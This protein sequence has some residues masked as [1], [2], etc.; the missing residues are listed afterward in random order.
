MKN[1][2][3]T[4][5]LLFI[6]V[7]SFAQ[8]G[9]VFQGIA[10]DDQNSAMINKTLTFTFKIKD[11]S[12]TELFTENK[13]LTTDAFGVFS[14]TIGSVNISGFNSVEFTKK[15]LRLEVTVNGVSGAIYDQ[16]FQ[17]VPYAK[18]AEIATRA[19]HGVPVGTILPFMG[20]TAPEGWVMCD[21]TNISDS[22]YDALRAVL[23]TSHTPDLR[24]R[25]LKGAGTSGMGIMPTSQYDQSSLGQYQSQSIMQH[26]HDKGSIKV[27][28]GEGGHKHA[29]KVYNENKSDKGYTQDGKVNSLT[30]TNR[31][32]SWITNHSDNYQ[33]E[34]LIGHVNGT[35]HHNHT[36]EGS[37][38]NTGTKENRPWSFSVNYIIKY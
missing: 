38:A 8:S 20:T 29:I 2:K 30:A 10:R 19:I 9:I 12:N 3:I 18:H 15:D 28:D 16:E 27:K 36:I 31:H 23:G 33:N 26:N 17:Y 7:V 25:F 22:K 14:H 32:G 13:S 11:P 6:T 24:G 5:L 34:A 21:N 37:T 4:L 35:G 1:L